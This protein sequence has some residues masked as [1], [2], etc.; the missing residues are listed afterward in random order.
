[1]ARKKIREFDAKNLLYS[2]LRERD[3]SLSS[4]LIPINQDIDI[5]NLS[6]KYPWL[7]DSALVVKPD[8]LFGKR[9]KHGLVLI[10]AKFEEVKRW[11]IEHM[12]K[13]V[14]IGKA[15]DK[16][17]HFLIEPFIEHTQEYYISFKSE[18]DCDI[19]YFSET[20]G[21]DIEDNWDN[22]KEIKVNSFQSIDPIVLDNITQI[23]IIRSFIKELFTIFKNLDFTYL[24]INP[25]TIV[26]NQIYL[27]DT[28]AKMDSCAAFKN[29]TSWNNITFPQEFGKKQ[30]SQEKYIEKI[31]ANS[32]ASL[33]LT[34]LNP[35]GRIWTILAGGGAS[36]IYLD[37]IANLGKGTQ[38]ANYGDLA[39]GPSTQESYEYAKTVFEL[40]TMEKDPKG[41]ILFILGGIANFT[42]VK[43]TFQG[44]IKALNEYQ[45][46]LKEHDVK[47]FIRRGGPNHQEG[48]KLIKETGDKLQ[49][50]MWVHGP[51]TSM[52]KIIQIAGEYL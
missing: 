14:T 44:F 1:M 49:L 45:Q 28:V 51:E 21:I 16:L 23:S 47:I 19:I 17:T 34:I 41:K 11:I 33:K 38:V 4:K 12:N 32:G 40:M 37:M 24:E 26:D 13:K 36:I 35:K 7:L 30:F 25:F 9:K 50:P 42:D 46:K 39:G 43:K 6:R 31:D 52:E 15:T 29:K 8:Q 48:L 27:L 20:G 22:V 2:H 3:L 18:R 5:E 10:N